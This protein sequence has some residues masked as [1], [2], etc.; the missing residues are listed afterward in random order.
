MT[1]MTFFLIEWETPESVAYEERAQDTPTEAAWMV[2]PFFR[3]NVLCST[4]N[5]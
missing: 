1:V 3:E 5:F 4:S 2:G